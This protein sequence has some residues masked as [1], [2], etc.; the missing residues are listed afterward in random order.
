LHRLVGW[1]IAHQLAAF[2]KAYLQRSWNDGQL[3]EGL[4]ALGQ[5]VGWLEY[6]SP[7]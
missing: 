1:D 6:K 4:M 7:D 5:G 3:V 2:V